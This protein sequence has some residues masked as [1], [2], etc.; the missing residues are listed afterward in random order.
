MVVVVLIVA[1]LAGVLVSVISAQ[2]VW[3]YAAAALSLLALAILVGD[4]VRRRI[5]AARHRAPADEFDEAEE[6]AD[7]VEPVVADEAEVPEE[8]ADEIV[9]AESLVLVIP[10]RKRY[11]RP[12]CSSVD[13][14]VTEEVTVAEATTEGFSPCTKCLADHSVLADV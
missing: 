12:G 11:H 5:V 14:F 2:L 7:I 1:G 9:P 8:T 4:A 10:G 6:P 13:G 3:A